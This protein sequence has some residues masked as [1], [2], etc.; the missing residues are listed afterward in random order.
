MDAER[1]TRAQVVE[2][3]TG[4]EDLVLDLSQATKREPR[5]WQVAVRDD[6]AEV[7]AAYLGDLPAEALVRVAAFLAV[8]AAA[9][10]AS[11]VGVEGARRRLDGQRLDALLLEEPVVDEPDRDQ[12]VTSEPLTCGDTPG[13]C[14]Q[15]RS[16]EGGGA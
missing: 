12:D 14:L 9:L 16:G 5:R 1:L 7:A 4:A 8:E 3:A 6:A 11:R 15:N 13:T 2:H 10:A